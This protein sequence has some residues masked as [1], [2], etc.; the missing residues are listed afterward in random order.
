MELARNESDTGIELA[1][2]ESGTGI[3]L[4][5]IGQEP[6]KNEQET[7]LELAKLTRNGSGTGKINEER[8]L[9]E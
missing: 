5:E 3:E 2:N 7:S 9:N 8:T 6:A 1:R 4:I